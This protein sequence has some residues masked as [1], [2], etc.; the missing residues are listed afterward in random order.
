MWQIWNLVFLLPLGGALFMGVLLSM[1]VTGDHGHDVSHEIGHDVGHDVGHGGHDH[2]HEMGHD[3]VGFMGRF[4]SFMGVGRVPLMV[5]LL[6]F[7]ATWGVTGLI[8]N[9]LLAPVLRSGMVYMW[10]SLA[11]AAFVSVMGTSWLARIIGK[12]MPTTSTTA[13]ARSY[14]VGRM[15]DARYDITAD[16]G[17]ATLRDEHGAFLELP[18]CVAV[19]APAIPAGARVVLREYDP[20][21]QVFIV[22]E[23]PLSQ[24]ES[25]PE[26]KG[27]IT[28][29]P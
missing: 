8:L 23:N 11:G 17:A 7:C 19:D 2:D 20:V 24:L 29:G 25:G 14:F 13:H 27:R 4:L 6:T 10:P 1:G 12:V 26:P 5:L 9:Q 16:S 21:R 15:A 18:C 3:D 22:V 28:G